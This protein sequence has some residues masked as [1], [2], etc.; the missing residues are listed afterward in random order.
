MLGQQDGRRG[1]GKFANGVVLDIGCGDRWAENVLPP[2]TVYLGLDYP[3][4]VSLGYSGRPDVFA[5]ARRLPLAKESVD[6][7]LLMDVLE[8]LPEPEAAIAEASRIL[9]PGGILI[10]QVPFLYPLHDEPYDFQ[11]WTIHG[12]QGLLQ[13]HKFN[14][15]ESSTQGEPLETAAALAVIAM[16]K[17]ILDGA[18]H[19][20]LVILLAPLLLI[21]IPLV[22][23]AGWLFAR[24]LPR[25]SLMPL[26]YRMVAAK[27]K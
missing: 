25:S 14:I 10:V 23:L 11:R 8:H 5:D 12:L 4:T 7:V 24:L 16:A 17:G 21:G 27:V 22:N 13:R 20:T 9:K 3:A 19:R 6:T 18:S 15:L 2:H 26:G 1:I